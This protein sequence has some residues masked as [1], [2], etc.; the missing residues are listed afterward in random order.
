MIDKMKNRLIRLAI[1]ALLFSVFGCAVDEND[2]LKGTLSLDYCELTPYE[3]EVIVYLHTDFDW[4]SKEIDQATHEV[5][6]WVELPESGSA[7]LTE[8]KIRVKS[9]LEDKAREC[10]ITFTAESSVMKLN[11]LDIKQGIARLD[12]SEDSMLW[13]WNDVN[14]K[15]LPIE[16]N[17]KLGITGHEE[18]WNIQQVTESNEFLCYPKNPNLSNK[19]IVTTIKIV[20]DLDSTR[21]KEIQLIHEAFVFSL[22]GVNDSV[23]YELSGND[24]TEKTIAVVCDDSWDLASVSSDSL[25]V[26]VNEQSVRYQIVGSDPLIEDQIVNIALKA[27][28]GVERNIEIS[29][30]GYKE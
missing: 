11:S 21:Q 18:Y 20:P 10:R 6:D 26:S 4:E 7:G 24:F 14:Q 2:E 13:A 8:V 27:A 15:T 16:T 23:S 1:T 22:D 12:V 17:L 3:T 9:N 28:C 25:D 29:I 5:A 19:P 30:K